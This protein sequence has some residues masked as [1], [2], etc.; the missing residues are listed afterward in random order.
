LF[1]KEGR[2]VLR[3]LLNAMEI[4]VVASKNMA[5]E[6]EVTLSSRVRY[7]FEAS[8]I[9]EALTP[10]EIPAPATGKDYLSVLDLRR[11]PLMKDA[12]KRDRQTQAI[13]GR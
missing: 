2:I 7:K 13:R 12:K 6:T 10:K 8:A 1:A 4:G 11:F 3:F 9:R 5:G